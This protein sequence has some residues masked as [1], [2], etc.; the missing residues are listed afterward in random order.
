MRIKPEF[1][2]HTAICTWTDTQGHASW[3]YWVDEGLPLWETNISRIPY[4]IDFWTV[5]ETPGNWFPKLSLHTHNQT[6]QL[7]VTLQHVMYPS[8]QFVQ[9]QIC[10]CWWN[11]ELCYVRCVG[12]LLVW[13]VLKYV[14]SFSLLH[15][16]WIAGITPLVQPLLTCARD[17]SDNYPKFLNGFCILI[18][19][20]HLEICF[21]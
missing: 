5:L 9:L 2:H 12:S 11:N 7:S 19:C 18:W 17:D 15:C 3:S 20:R 4:Q 10:V 21:N 13:I 16:Q 14:P 1:E 6:K 8:V